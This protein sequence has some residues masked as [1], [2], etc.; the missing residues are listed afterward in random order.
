MFSSL[1]GSENPLS[2]VSWVEDGNN[3]REIQR[4]SFKNLLRIPLFF[5]AIH[6]KREST[7]HKC[8]DFNQTCSSNSLFRLSHLAAIT[9]SAWGP[10]TAA[11]PV[12]AK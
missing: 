11:L 1:Y 12:M 8:W 5:W 6:I 2:S 9:S 7:S 4:H 3:V 10:A